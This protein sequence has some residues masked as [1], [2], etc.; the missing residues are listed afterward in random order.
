MPSLIQERG[1]A[2]RDEVVRLGR[3]ERIAEAEWEALATR[4]FHLHRWFVAAERCGWQPRHVGI[5]GESGLAAIVPVF[6]ADHRTLHDLRY[7]WLGPLAVAVAKTG[8]D[9]RPTITVQSPFSAGSDPLGSLFSVSDDALHSVF[10]TLERQA[11]EDDAV[12]AVWPFIEAGWGDR[13]LRVGQ[14]VDPGLRRRHGPAADRLGELRGV[15]R[16][17]GG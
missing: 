8:L 3:A 12:A 13:L 6:L 1:L 14:G 10:S 11:V 5:T 17:P 9:L 4:G 2:S 7:R 16:Q 15:C